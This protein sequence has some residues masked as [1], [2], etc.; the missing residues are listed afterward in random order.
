MK[1]FV[2]KAGGKLIDNPK[3]CKKFLKSF[4]Q[5]EGKKLLVHGGG[6]LANKLLEQLN[7]K[8]S[9]IAGRRVTDLETLDV[10]TMV[11]AGILS[12]QLVCQLQAMKQNAIGLSG[13]DANL[14]L[15]RKRDKTNGVSYGYA[16]DVDEVNTNFL[17]ELFEHHYIP[18]IN[19]ITHDGK[20]QR[21][22]T[23]AD[24]VASAIA[25]ALAKN[26]SYQVHLLYTFNYPGVLSQPGTAQS[27]LKEINQDKMLDLQKR[28]AIDAGM[29]PKLREAFHAVQKDVKHVFIGDHLCMNFWNNTESSQRGTRIKI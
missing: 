25:I 6:V 21:L 5:L 26:P 20:G 14:I 18:V 23:N 27:V 13:C 7:I 24:T 11:Y 1:V 9:F 12:K 16:G 22:N 10:I 19:S 2:I 8:P 28:G 4:S 15:C 17:Q 29:L 3:N